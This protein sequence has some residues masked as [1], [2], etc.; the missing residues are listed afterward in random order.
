MPGEGQGLPAL[1]QTASM[2]FCIERICN[3]A[4]R[5]K[6]RFHVSKLMSRDTSEPGLRW[7]GLK[8]LQHAAQG[9]RATVEFVARHKL[10]GRAARLH[11]CSRFVFEN[12]RWFYVDDDIL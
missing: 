7:L 4:W 12:G 11:A 1:A 5:T 9:S 10:C 3:D 8:V 2:H 6:A